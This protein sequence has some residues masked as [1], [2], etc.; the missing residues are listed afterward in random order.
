MQGQKL[1]ATMN[2]FGPN[3]QDH[4]FLPWPN[5]LCLFFRQFEMVNICLPY[6]RFLQ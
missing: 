3:L 2:I 6:L 4:Q 1:K 5:P